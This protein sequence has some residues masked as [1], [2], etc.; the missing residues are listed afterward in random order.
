MLMNEIDLSDLFKSILIP[1]YENF[2]EL[3]QVINKY[4]SD[5][6][7]AS[8][9]CATVHTW[10]EEHGI[11]PVNFFDMMY[12]AVAQQVAEEKENGLI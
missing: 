10:C 4:N 2:H 6:G 9:I 8:A 12:S 1:D 5:T 7:L 3:T 11:D